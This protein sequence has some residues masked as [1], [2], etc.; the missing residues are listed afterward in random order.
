MNR[1]NTPKKHNRCRRSLVQTESVCAGVS[2]NVH[3]STKRKEDQ[4]RAQ[5]FT[6]KKIMVV[7]YANELNCPKFSSKEDDHEGEGLKMTLKAS[8]WG[9]LKGNMHEVAA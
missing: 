7:N 8:V 1:S 3:L 9:L 2:N 4:S 6:K 5:V